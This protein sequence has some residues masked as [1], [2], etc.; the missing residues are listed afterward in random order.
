[1]FCYHA[2]SLRTGRDID[3]PWDIVS[4]NFL[5]GEKDDNQ[6]AQY[7]VR[8]FIPEAHDSIYS[9][10]GYQRGEGSYSSFFAVTPQ[11]EDY[12]KRK[13]PADTKDQ[14]LY[15]VY[16][17][18]RE[19]V[20]FWNNVSPDFQERVLGPICSEAL[21][22][23]SRST[24]GKHQNLSKLNNTALVV[25]CFLCK[26]LDGTKFPYFSQLQERWFVLD[27]KLMGS[28]H[29]P[30]HRGWMYPKGCKPGTKEEDIAEKHGDPLKESVP[31]L[32]SKVYLQQFLASTAGE[33]SL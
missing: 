22:A 14:E 11:L 18:G 30:L 8:P 9:C 6:Q 4:K 7:L 32:L 33:W 24:M 19:R 5:G 31:E 26:P 1:M 27:V 16:L 29:H 21:S 15:E 28:S 12:P 10:Y 23:L 25:E 2:Q 20:G 17:T 3:N 13:I